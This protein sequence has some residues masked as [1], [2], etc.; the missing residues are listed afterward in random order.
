MIVVSEVLLP[1]VRKK[2][3]TKWKKV[4]QDGNVPKGVCTAVCNSMIRFADDLTYKV[5]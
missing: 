3:S 1:K 2:Y 4:M 5:A